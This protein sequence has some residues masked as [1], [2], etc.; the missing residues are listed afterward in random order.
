MAL[1]PAARVESP[2]V[3]S[4]NDSQGGSV[5]GDYR[6]PE[7][8]RQDQAY[9]REGGKP[10]GER[11]SVNEDRQALENLY[12]ACLL[13]TR[14]LGGERGYFPSV[15]A[16]K[17]GEFVAAVQDARQHLGANDEVFYQFGG[18]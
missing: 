13:I 16:T 3:G 15:G 10:E 7:D 17:T 2:V 6:R 11:V 5:A 18:E 9:R 12:R 1:Y 4:G 14:C 8:E